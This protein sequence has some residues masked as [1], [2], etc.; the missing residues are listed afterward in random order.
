MQI[1]I[2]MSRRE[3]AVVERQFSTSGAT[4]VSELVRIQQQQ[5]NAIV[6]GD[7]DCTRFDLLL[8]MA[9]KN[10]CRE[11]RVPASFR[12]PRVLDIP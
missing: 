5:F 1:A 10:I 6:E 3:E 4:V 12:R 8:H 11:I 7:S 9:N 2:W